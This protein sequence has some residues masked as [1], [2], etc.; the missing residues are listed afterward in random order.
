MLKR[1][2]ALLVA[3]VLVISGCG[4]SASDRGDYVSQ[5]LP[6]FHAANRIPG[7]SLGDSRCVLEYLVTTQGVDGTKELLSNDGA[8][9]PK[10]SLLLNA[11]DRC[12]SLVQSFREELEIG[13]PTLSA[14]CVVS[15][16]TD[17]DI[18]GWRYTRLTQGENAYQSVVTRYINSKI[19]SCSRSTATKVRPT[20]TTRAP[21]TAGLHEF[22]R[23][24]LK[25]L[26]NACIA[27]AAEGGMDVAGG[28]RCT[29]MVD[30]AADVYNS[31]LRACTY[32]DVKSWIERELWQDP[33]WP[34]FVE[35]QCEP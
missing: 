2:L 34:L 28:Y 27:K 32:E 7:M 18:V 4:E 6:S 5:K 26:D 21:S 31:S 22:S 16:L 1:P 15:G 3:A 14:S 19:S 33:E 11:L 24:E 23:A 10:A 8:I 9:G 12:V 13:A 17:Q 35:R 29:W 20:T 30:D 25:S